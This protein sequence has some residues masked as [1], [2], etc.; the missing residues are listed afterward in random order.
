MDVIGLDVQFHYLALHLLGL[1][2]HAKFHL[3]FDLSCQHPIPILRTPNNVIFAKPNR[4]RLFLES[5]HAL[6]LSL[7]VGTTRAQDYHEQVLR[8]EPLFLTMSR[9]H[10]FTVQQ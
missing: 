6:F 9:G 5:A 8:A 1:I 7:V 3:L 2:P 4:M 10:G